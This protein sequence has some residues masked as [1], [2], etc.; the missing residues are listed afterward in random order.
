[1]D[2]LK[3]AEGTVGAP[4]CF[5]HPNLSKL[6]TSGE[7][8]GSRANDSSLKRFES[9]AD[10]SSLLFLAQKS[11]KDLNLRVMNRCLVSPLDQV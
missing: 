6:R 9:L 1:M 11:P 4:T 5:F 8:S 7:F 10:D 2:P 3:M